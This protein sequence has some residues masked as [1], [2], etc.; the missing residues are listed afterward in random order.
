MIAHPSPANP[1]ANRGWEPLIEKQ[2]AEL[3]IKIGSKK[4]LE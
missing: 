3:G 2:L 1:Q 4:H